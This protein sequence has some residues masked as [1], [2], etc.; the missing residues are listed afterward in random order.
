M[1]ITTLGKYQG[2]A[3]VEQNIEGFATLHVIAD[4]GKGQWDV[5]PLLCRTF[6]EAK[7]A[8]DQWI[9]FDAAMN[10]PE[11]DVPFDEDEAERLWNDLNKK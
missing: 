8:I 2:F 9:A 4:E 6:D 7:I 11:E 10:E 1:A 5:F 3:V